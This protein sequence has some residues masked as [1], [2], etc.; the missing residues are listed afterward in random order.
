MVLRI[1]GFQGRVLRQGTYQ[2]QPL[3]HKTNLV[4]CLGSKGN[5]LLYLGQYA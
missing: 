2:T 5:Q 1:T 3:K 4:F